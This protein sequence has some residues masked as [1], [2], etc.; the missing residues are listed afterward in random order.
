M[1]Q[2]ADLSPDFSPAALA[3]LKA[4]SGDRPGSGFAVHDLRHL[5]WCSIDNDDSRD[6]DQ[7]TVAEPL[8]KGASGS[9]WPSPTWTRS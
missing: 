3:E 4:L 2:S 1:L 8:E 6:L 5:T 9:G 7:L